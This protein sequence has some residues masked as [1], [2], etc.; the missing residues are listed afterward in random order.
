MSASPSCLGAIWSIGANSPFTPNC[1]RHD[2][3]VACSLGAMAA[4]RAEDAATQQR[5]ISTVHNRCT[6]LQ[7][8][9]RNA[10]STKRFC[11][12][13]PLP[14]R[15]SAS[16]RAGSRRRAGRILELGQRPAWETI[17]YCDK[18]FASD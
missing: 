15:G 10:R 2:H 11:C 1:V 16:P 8:R 12:R 9:F 4:Q 17:S 14:R 6:R 18:D 13:P 7:P 3:A 5:A